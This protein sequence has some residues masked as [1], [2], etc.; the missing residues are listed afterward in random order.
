VFSPTPGRCGIWRVLGLTL[1]TDKPAKR[2]LRNLPQR[3]TKSRRKAFLVALEQGARI[4]AACEAIGASKQSLYKL[5][6]RDPAFAKAM[7]EAL[8]R[9]IVVIEDEIARRAIEGVQKPIFQGGQL[10]G[11]VTEYSDSLLLALAKR[12]DPEHWKDR[13]AS[14]VTATVKTEDV[15]NGMLPQEVEQRL[16]RMVQIYL[17][18]RKANGKAVEGESVATH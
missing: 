2:D 13:T 10:V 4:V 7:D 12:R 16:A 18:N 5:R 11:H 9:S 17:Q 15:L 3:W 6:Q 8:G 1:T 14:E